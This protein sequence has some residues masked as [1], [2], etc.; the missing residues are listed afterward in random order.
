MKIPSDIRKED[1]Q[2]FWVKKSKKPDDEYMVYLDFDGMWSCEC[3]DY[4]IHLPERGMPM[5]HK[6]KHILRCM[7]L[8]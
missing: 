5:K 1:D 4:W 2:T 7:L 6:C 8:V 3:T